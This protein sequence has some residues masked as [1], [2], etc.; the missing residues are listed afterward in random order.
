[1]KKL[2]VI[3][4]LA[5]LFTLQ[6]KAQTEPA[7]GNFFKVAPSG[8]SSFGSIPSYSTVLKTRFFVFHQGA[9]DSIYVYYNNYKPL[10]SWA[11]PNWTVGQGSL[12]YL[13]YGLLSSDTGH[14]EYVMFGANGGH[15]SLTMWTSAG[16]KIFSCDSC[17]PASNNFVAYDSV[18]SYMFLNKINPT[19]PSVPIRHMVVKLGGKTVA[20]TYYYVKP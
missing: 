16:L 4:I 20:P 3:S 18:A 13:S 2:I 9:T 12:I 14:Y 10:T 1:M 7:I 6:G 15:D 8:Y 17:M 11:V 5:C 19:M